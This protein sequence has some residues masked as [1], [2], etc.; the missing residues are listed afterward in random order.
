MRRAAYWLF[1]LIALA[2]AVFIAI[3]LVQINPSAPKV[4][5]SEYKDSSK[6][7]DSIDEK[8]WISHF[9]GSS[10]KEYVYPV[11]EVTLKLNDSNG[12]TFQN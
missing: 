12:T 8:S 4:N 10:K 2:V 6:N 5:I 7:K 9:T 11:N 1:P 3:F